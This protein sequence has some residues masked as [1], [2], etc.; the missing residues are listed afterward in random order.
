MSSLTFEG[1]H[2]LVLGIGAR[3]AA[4]RQV[5]TNT[6][7][8]LT[9][10]F[11]SSVTY[12]VIDRSVS[13]SNPTLQAARRAAVPVITTSELQR[14]PGME[15]IGTGSGAGA[16]YRSAP[17]AATTVS[18]SHVSP[19]TVVPSGP[20]RRPAVVPHPM[21]P[22][23]SP[24]LPPA[25]V[26]RNEGLDTAIGC[27]AL[28][29]CTSGLAMPF[30]AGYFAI[31]QKS[32]ALVAVAA[33]YLVPTLF[34]LF[35]LFGPLV[36]PAVYF[37]MV[38]VW[39]GLWAGGTVHAF[40]MGK[41]HGQ[42]KNAQRQLPGASYHPGNAA[43]LAKVRALRQLREEARQVVAQDPSMARDL[44]IGRPD[45]P[46]SYNDG[47]LIDV[48]AVSADVLVQLPGVTEVVAQEIVTHRR[49]VGPFMDGSDVMFHTSMVPAE[50]ERFEE[51]AVF[52]R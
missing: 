15:S 5:L 7:A 22:P 51:V 16:S 3:A 42:R 8:I 21:Q 47:G 49:D 36:D 23:M 19:P 28:A 44:K 35:M 1:A 9:D 40:M 20:P 33:G 46:R 43:A 29:F 6:G 17:P 38:L 45:L 30:V 32:G 48:N 14:V 18:A 31:R 11:S 13:S 10:R 52:L 12:V 4:A 25:T 24:Q 34:I 27:L 26:V 50:R 41:Q 37:L 2:V 39:L